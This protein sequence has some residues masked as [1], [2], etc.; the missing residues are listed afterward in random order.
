MR[1]RGRRLRFRDGFELGGGEAGAKRRPPFV[2]GGAGHGADWCPRLLLASSPWLSAAVPSAEPRS[3]ASTATRST[4]AI[5][6]A[7][8]L[9]TGVCA[10]ARQTT[11]RIPTLGGSR[12][13]A[14]SWR[15]PVSSGGV[16]ALPRSGS[17]TRTARRCASGVAGRWRRTRSPSCRR[18]LRPA[19]FSRT[20][21][22]LSGT[23]FR[24]KWP[25]CS[26]KPQRELGVLGHLVQ[27]RSREAP[28]N[29]HFFGTVGT[30]VGTVSRHAR[31]GR[32]LVGRGL[33]P[34]CR[35]SG[36]RSGPV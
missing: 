9:T 10:T 31:P 27:R 24:P 7:A 6:A 18:R 30:A 34:R 22:D 25:I 12:S 15:P 3:S 19:H 23:P 11:T 8:T 17:S 32:R 26:L 36:G 5:S 29:A 4:A 14:D 16:S 21:R 20:V 35:A 33:R 13:D 2:A 28:A 1:R